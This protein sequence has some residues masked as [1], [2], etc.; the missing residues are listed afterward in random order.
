MWMPTTFGFTKAFSIKAARKLLCP[1]I[2]NRVCIA[3]A[4]SRVHSGS[5][6]KPRERS[7]GFEQGRHL[8]IRERALAQRCYSHSSECPLAGHDRNTQRTHRP[9]RLRARFGITAFVALQVA[10]VDGLATLDGE[11]RHTLTN[12]DDACRRQNRFGNP[13]GMRSQVKQAIG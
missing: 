7:T 9:G 8:G 2:A 12:R 4:S 6:V 3:T 10:E 5:R 11:S 13:G 1:S